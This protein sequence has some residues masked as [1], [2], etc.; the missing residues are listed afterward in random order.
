MYINLNINV[1]DALANSE[2][3][4]K[5]NA[6]INVNYHYNE[7]MRETLQDYSSTVSSFNT[8]S[9]KQILVCKAL[10]EDSKMHIPET[11]DETFSS[12]GTKIRAIPPTLGACY[13]EKYVVGCRASPD[14]P[15][16]RRTGG[17]G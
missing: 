10:V 17:A 2:A 5:Q 13:K 11:A 12:S 14:A 7:K 9:C 16:G 3:H 4:I 6:K 1:T 8:H 15:V